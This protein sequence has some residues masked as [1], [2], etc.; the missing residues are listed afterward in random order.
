MVGFLNCRTLT[1]GTDMLAS[2]DAGVLGLAGLSPGKGSPPGLH[3]GVFSAANYL[4]I[5]R[6]SSPTPPPTPV[7]PQSPLLPRVLT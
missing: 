6:I 2:L 1:L 5:N 4:H 3:K 7:H